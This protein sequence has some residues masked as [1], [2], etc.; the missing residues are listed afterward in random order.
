MA[1][2]TATID[3]KPRTGSIGQQL[4]ATGYYDLAGAITGHATT[5]DTITFDNI[6]PKGGAK[7]ISV[8]V[9]YPELD[10]HATPTGTCIVGNTDDDNGFAITNN[11]GLPAQLPANTQQVQIC[12]TGDLVGTSITN[13]DV[14]IEFTA[15]LATSA[16]TGRV[17]LEVLLEAP[18]A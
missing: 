9:T 10:T 18:A 4:L 2:Y 1:N 6:I 7:I 12:G 13:R 15:A 5:G 16:T 3:T 14:I 11:V 17:R 8:G